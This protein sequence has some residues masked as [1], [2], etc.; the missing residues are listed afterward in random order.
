[1]GL[2]FGGMGNI[3]GNSLNQGDGFGN[4][5]GYEQGNLRKSSI[6]RSALQTIATST[7]VDVIFDSVEYDDLSSW[8][9]GDPTKIK[10]KETGIYLVMARASFSNNSTGERQLIVENNN[11]QVIAKNMVPTSS[12]GIVETSKMI[13]LTENDELTMSVRQTSGGDLTVPDSAG[14]LKTYLQFIKISNI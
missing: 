4:A 13:Q 6:W 8:D 9:S 14:E 3:F 12:N 10:I 11:S 7:T 2:D 1:M 5:R